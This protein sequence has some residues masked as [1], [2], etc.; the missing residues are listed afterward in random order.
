MEQGKKRPTPAISEHTGDIIRRRVYGRG[1]R[2][3]K[4]R[5]FSSNKED[6]GRKKT[7]RKCFHR[8]EETIREEN[9]GLFR[10]PSKEGLVSRLLWVSEVTV[11]EGTVLKGGGV[12]QLLGK[13]SRG[14]S[15]QE[16]VE[17]LSRHISLKDFR[18][19]RRRSSSGSSPDSVRGGEHGGKE[20][21]SLIWW[22]P[23]GHRG[24]GGG[25]GGEGDRIR[26]P[27]CWCGDVGELDLLSVLI[28]RGFIAVRREADRD[29][30]RG[31][32]AE[33]VGVRG[34]LDV[35]DERGG[36]GDRQG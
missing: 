19:K 27:I 21:F 15:A 9:A 34:G 32:L 17:R 28:G 13:T 35:D 12:Q 25:G 30:E 2:K 33:G 11:E 18:G 3:E 16:K 24:G 8:L 4:E 22:L 14:P 26:G 1:L 6:Q 36:G 23:K 31:E 7:L 29:G 5:K 10:M 20:G